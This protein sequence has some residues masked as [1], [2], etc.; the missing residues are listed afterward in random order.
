MA[1]N[2]AAVGAAV[3]ILGSVYQVYSG[4]R[5]RRNAKKDMEKLMKE[6]HQFNVDPAY[7]K[8]RDLASYMAQ[9]GLDDQSYQFY[10]TQNERALA[11]ANQ[12]SLEA[13]GG[14]NSIQK[15]YDTSLRGFGDLAAKNAVLKSDNLKLL[16]DNNVALA[17]QNTM[18]WA[19]DFK[20]W[21]DQNQ[22]GINAMNT[23]AQN[24]AS[25]LSNLGQGLSNYASVYNGNNRGDS[26]SQ[27]AN[28]GSDP[29]WQVN[30]S[31]YVNPDGSQYNP[32]QGL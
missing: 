14:V 5:D 7:S 18:Q 1:G 6:D 12:A 4:I 32:N 24:T 19:I 10:K 3:G 9:Q 22:R 20:K 2:L 17:G 30:G 21:Q 28:P 31:G 11:N 13:G 27:N 26:G 23:G 16:M 8:N 29:A 15:N 25:G